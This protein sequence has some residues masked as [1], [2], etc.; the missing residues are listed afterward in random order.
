M[1]IIFSLAVFRL[2]LLIHEEDGPFSIL[3]L[4]RK[5]WR[6]LPGLGD[7]VDCVYCLSV[8]TGATAF[9]FQDWK[10]AILWLLGS[11]AVTVLLYEL[12]EWINPK[13][14]INE[15]TE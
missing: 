9:F 6:K 3:I 8:W 5:V 4:F 10:T 12:R 1:F 2:T 14:V 15:L 13:V 11:S 7:V